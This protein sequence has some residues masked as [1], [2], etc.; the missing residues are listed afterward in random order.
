MRRLCDD[1]GAATAEYVI[2][3]M[4][5]VGFA[6]LLIVILRGDEVRGILTDLVRNALTVG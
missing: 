5:A 3:T 6:G 2:A 1:A 4:A